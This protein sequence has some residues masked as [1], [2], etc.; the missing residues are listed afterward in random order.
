[1]QASVK[2]LY[3]WLLLLRRAHPQKSRLCT[4]PTLTCLIASWGKLEIF[5]L[6]FETHKTIS[7]GFSALCLSSYK[8]GFKLHNNPKTLFEINIPMQ[9]IGSVVIF[10]LAIDKNLR[11]VSQSWFS[12]FTFKYLKSELLQKILV[13]PTVWPLIASSD[14]G[15]RFTSAC[16]RTRNLCANGCGLR[17]GIGVTIILE[18]STHFCDNNHQLKRKCWLC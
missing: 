1:M 17:T 15:V 16:I 8:I 5:L 14:F 3:C 11:H 10:F 4:S 13:R 9:V 2:V 18:S 6:R 12:N 7:F